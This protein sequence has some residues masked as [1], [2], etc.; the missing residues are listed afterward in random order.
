MSIGFDYETAWD[1]ACDSVVEKT[2]RRRDFRLPYG[3]VQSP[4]LASLVLDKSALGRA[5]AKVSK[6]GLTLSVYMDDIIV[7]G[8]DRS[9]VVD[10]NEFLRSATVQ[11]SFKINE[12][13]SSEVSTEI[14]VFN[15]SISHDAATI[16][17]GRMEEFEGAL[18]MGDR[19]VRE[20][21]MSYVETVNPSQADDLRALLKSLAH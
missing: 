1:I 5:L 14:T 13:K 4:I 12:G 10:A 21:I 2:P 9:S 18:E 17:D 15:I 6:S 19:S 16:I 7:S 11:S 3:F 8:A 20:G